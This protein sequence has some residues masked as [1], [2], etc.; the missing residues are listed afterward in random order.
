MWMSEISVLWKQLEFDSFTCGCYIPLAYA[1]IDGTL[2]TILV[3]FECLTFTLLEK[4]TSTGWKAS[5]LSHID[6]GNQI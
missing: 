5:D 1:A 4:T 6:T 2:T 3:S